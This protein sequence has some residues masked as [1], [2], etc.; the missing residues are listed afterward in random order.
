MFGEPACNWILAWN[1]RRVTYS[2]TK[3]TEVAASLVF[4][5]QSPCMG[6]FLP[7]A[8]LSPVDGAVTAAEVADVGG[9]EMDVDVDVEGVV[10][11]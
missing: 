8:S 11:L 10:V 9:S 3:P 1:E 7:N 2:T 5:V 6:L 4:V